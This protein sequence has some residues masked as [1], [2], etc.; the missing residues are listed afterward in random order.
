MY[1]EVIPGIWKRAVLN[2]M[3]ESQEMAPCWIG[4][5]VLYLYMKSVVSKLLFSESFC[6]GL[7]YV[8]MFQ[9]NGLLKII[10]PYYKYS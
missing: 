7:F 5:Y 1:S 9:G 2:I 10:L 3:I 4:R 8:E 6:H